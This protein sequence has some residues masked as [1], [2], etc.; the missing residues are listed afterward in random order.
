MY[1]QGIPCADCARGIIQS[2]V[3]TV[4]YH[5]QWQV[6]QEKLDKD[7]SKKWIESVERTRIM[8]KESK[9]NLV[10]Y[11]DKVILNIQARVSETDINV[12]E[13]TI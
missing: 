4:Y 7:I 12:N 6:F 8:F 9:V 2:G 10:S 11:Y 13:L 1:T 5:K 3:V